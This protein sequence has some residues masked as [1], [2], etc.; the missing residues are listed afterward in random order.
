MNKVFGIDISKWQKGFDFK[1][2]K[3]E[4][5][6]FVILRGA[7]GNGEDTCFESFYKNAKKVG[8]NV[9]VYQFGLA[10]NE[11]Q[12]REEARFLINNCLKDKQFE[13]PIY[14]DVES[15][16]QLDLSKSE[17][18]KVIIAWCEEIEEAGYYAG[19]YTNL[20]CYKNE[21]S[22]STLNKKYDWWLAHWTTEK[23][24]S[25]IIGNGAG[26]WQFGGEGNYIRTT[27][28]SNFNIIDQDYSYKDYPSIMKKY[29]LNG[30]SKD[31]TNNTTNN[32]S[33]PQKIENKPTTTQ[34]TTSY[35]TYTVKRGDTL[36]KIANKYGT[37]YQKLAS[38]NGISN[39][40]KIKVGQVIKIPTSSTSKTT[41]YT[42]KSGDTLSSI[43][44]KY[45]TTVNTIVR[46]NNIKDPN[47][48]YV[49][50]KLVIKG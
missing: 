33:T 22:G 44:K 15:K 17:L 48:I 16:L 23:N 38:Y 49:G 45:G 18:D 41:T 37:T 10:V 7:Y 46:D 6:N 27:K 20:S 40:N 9:G 11:A 43:A 50:Q 30:Y 3:N 19:V 31:K 36:S 2:A 26:M 14:Y 8:L 28:V 47:K 29:G 5:V 39:P 21:C 25:D 42:V 12:A 35:T 4:G 13:Y 34:N 24:K 32:T 1:K